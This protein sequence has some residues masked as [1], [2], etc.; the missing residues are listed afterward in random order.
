MTDNRIQKLLIANRGEIALRI[1]KACRKL[2]IST[3]SIASEVDQSTFFARQ[4]EELV[5][6]G[7][8]SAK[9]S[10]LAA[11]KIIRAARER[12]CNAIHPGYG[13]LSENAGFARKVREAGLIFVGPTPEAID[14]LG[15][16]I[17]AR[18]KA[19]EAGVPTPEGAMDILHEEQLVAEAEKIG[20]PVIVKAVGG[21]GGR[22]MRIAHSTEELR[23][24]LPRARAEALKNFGNEAVYFEKYIVNPRHVEVQLFGDAFGKVLHFGTR[25]CS[26]QRRHQKL[27]EE[28]PAP[29]LSPDL[30]EGIHQAAVKIASSVQYTNAGTAEFLVKDS[31]FYFLEMNT[32]IQVEH[33]VT[34]MITGVDL[35]ELQLL[36][37]QG[38]PLP[39]S[40]S[41]VSFHGHAIE[42]R[43]YAEDPSAGFTPT[44]GK[45]TSFRS[46]KSRWLRDERGYEVG[47]D[48]SLFYDAMLT[49]IIVTGRDRDEAVCNSRVIL[50]DYQVEGLKTTLPFHEWMLRL[51]PFRLGPVDINFVERV[52][53]PNALEELSAAKR[54]DPLYKLP[55]GEIEYIEWFSYPAPLN[56]SIQIEVRHRRDGVFVAIPYLEGKRAVAKYCR[57]SNGREVALRA[58][59]EEVLEKVEIAE[60]FGLGVIQ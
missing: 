57:S 16:K 6:I 48:V 11:D 12:G 25:D 40:Q 50:N 55:D 37:A 21:G 42:Y 19:K 33:P 18:K 30:R 4:A 10:Y 56:Q 43:V 45:L 27:I 28:A 31:S 38:S 60:I 26:T 44:K 7:S 49:K 46:S 54:R 20:F 3:V 22:G 51:T 34:E 17:A 23:A 14:L 41:D 29:F 15:D 47:D 9:D 35:V 13:F 5:V 52:F 39:F 32:R 53:H 58:L 2:E 59:Q 1:Q 8:S 24:A 36:V